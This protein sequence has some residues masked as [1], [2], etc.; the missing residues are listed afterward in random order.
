MACLK[1]PQS[2]H[3]CHKLELSRIRANLT[4]RGL[5]VVVKKHNPDMIFLMET[6]NRHDKVDRLRA[7][8]NLRGVFILSH[9]VL[10]QGWPYGGNE[11]HWK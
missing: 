11:Y 5:K 1:K 2:S 4:I 6:W 3:D 8:C 10:L 7:R 9:E